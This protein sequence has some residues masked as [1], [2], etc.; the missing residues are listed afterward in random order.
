MASGFKAYKLANVFH[1]VEIIL[2]C[3]EVRTTGVCTGICTW[4]VQHIGVYLAVTS[5]GRVMVVGD[6][7]P[8]NN[9]MNLLCLKS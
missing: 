5:I 7:Y 6:Q 1:T 3:V 4:A 2:H 8:I 9:H